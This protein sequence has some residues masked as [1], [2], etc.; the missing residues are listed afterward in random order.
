MKIINEILNTFFF[1]FIKI[2][3]FGL[4]W[5]QVIKGLHTSG[6]I[7]TYFLLSV[8][9]G[10][11][12]LHGRLYWRPPA[13]QEW[14]L[15]CLQ[16]SLTIGLFFLICFADSLPQN[17]KSMSSKKC[18]PKESASF[19]SRILF[20]WFTSLTIKGWKKPL[21]TSD[22]WLI[23]DGYKSSTIHSEFEKNWENT[24]KKKGLKSRHNSQ[25]TVDTSLNGS[26]NGIKKY[27]IIGNKENTDKSQSSKKS[28]ESAKVGV[29]SIIIK[30]F[31]MY[32][33]GGSII[34]LI[35]DLLTFVNPQIM[36]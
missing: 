6:V 21:T 5:A 14:V 1:T 19:L 8:I 30:T 29:I 31:W 4:F 11:P 23:R 27:T 9:C 25:T 3:V 2:T 28:V 35:N 26:E 33:L 24:S 18:C 12:A 34:K 36:K 20:S 15:F 10:A 16:Y 32:F 13:L 17:E 7:W 22:L